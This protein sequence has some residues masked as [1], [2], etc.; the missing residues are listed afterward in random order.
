[1]KIKTLHA[2]AAGRWFNCSGSVKSSLVAPPTGGDTHASDEGTAA[3]RL[4]E[5]CLKSGVTADSYLDKT[6]KIE[7]A[8]VPTWEVNQEMVDHVQAGL[9]LVKR[10]RGK[11]EF[12]SEGRVFIPTKPIPVE[13]TFD[14]GWH[15][16]YIVNGKKERQLHLLDLKYG[17][18]NVEVTDNRQ[19]MIYA[20]GKL[21]EM[22]KLKKQV[23]S[24]HVWIY[25]PRSI[26]ADGPFRLQTYSVEDLMAFRKELEEKVKEVM[27]VK[28]HLNAGPWCLYCPAHAMCPE[29]EKA[30]LRTVRTKYREGDAARVGEL[31]L[32]LPYLKSWIKALENTAL[33]MA[34]AGSMPEGLKLVDG[35]RS[36]SWPGGGKKEP[37]KLT[38]LKEIMPLL[39]KKFG[40]TVDQIAPRRLNSPAAIEKQIDRAHRDELEEFYVWSAGKEKLVPSDDSRYT[41]S[42]NLYFEAEPDEEEEE[43]N[44]LI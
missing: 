37:E 33:T 35:K 20:L 12:W 8:S 43:E 13:G 19:L 18:I 34:H 25:Q 29:A 21:L 23:D 26:H 42:I 10:K 41:A 44:S 31:F 16:S 36:R 40:L 39:M 22:Q 11:G 5:L 17:W 14:A 4:F 24:V 7:R 6:M 1:V 28:L 15:G 3:H 27:S 2:S 38:Q 9:S 32:L 30:M